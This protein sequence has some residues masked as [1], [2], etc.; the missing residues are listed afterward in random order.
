ML[1]NRLG[2][3]LRGQSTEIF[4]WCNFILMRSSNHGCF[5]ERVLRNSV[6]A[7]LQ[8]A[9]AF[10]SQRDFAEMALSV[11]EIVQKLLIA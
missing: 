8:R 11:G 4:K 5:S 7:Q 6:R 2:A 1:W 10:R 9:V 3:G